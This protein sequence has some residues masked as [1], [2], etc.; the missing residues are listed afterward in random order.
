MAGRSLI[1]TLCGS[2]LGIAH[3]TV[4]EVARV[5]YAR[6]PNVASWIAR[7]KDR[8]TWAPVNEAFDKYLVQP[9]AEAQFEAL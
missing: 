5:D 8:P 9:C 2:R 4:A 6:W 1:T 7:M 3:I